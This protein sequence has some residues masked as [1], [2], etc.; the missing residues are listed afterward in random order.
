MNKLAAISII[1]QIIKPDEP[2]VTIRRKC[3]RSEQKKKC[4]YA[5][6]CDGY[7]PHCKHKIY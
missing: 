4:R 3:K 1:N 7:K 6:G 5:G 2:R